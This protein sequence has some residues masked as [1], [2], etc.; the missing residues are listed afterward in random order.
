MSCITNKCHL[1]FGT[2]PGSAARVGGVPSK[3]PHVE[4][5]WY[6]RIIQQSQPFFGAADNPIPLSLG[7]SFV[8]RT[9]CVGRASFHFNEYQRFFVA[10]AADQIDL[11]APFGPEVLIQQP[12]SISAEIVGG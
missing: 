3:P 1:A 4:S 10:I 11:T 9:E 12:K 5:I 2:L 6:P 7:H 8:R